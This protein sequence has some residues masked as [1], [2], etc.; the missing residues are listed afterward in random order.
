MVLLHRIKKKSC[1][2]LNRM[3][4][5]VELKAV[6]DSSDGH[7]ESILHTQLISISTYDCKTVLRM[8]ATTSGPKRQ[9]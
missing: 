6:V 2:E 1:G 3:P 8:E 7:G 5:S 4:W 9:R